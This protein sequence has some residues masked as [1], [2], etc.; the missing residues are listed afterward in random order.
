LEFNMQIKSISRHQHYAHI[1]DVTVELEFKP[2]Y[3]EYMLSERRGDKIVVAYLV[4]DDHYGDIQDLMGEATG[5]LYS[6]HRLGPR[7]DS[8]KAADAIENNVDAVLLDCY[9][10]GGQSWSMY[11]TGTQCQ[12]DTARG[13]GVWVP[14]EGLLEHLVELKG[15]KRRAQAI[16]FCKQFLETY[17][18]ILG[19]EV[20]G[21]V[22][23]TFQQDASDEDMWRRVSED[24]CWGFI[25]SK[26]SMESLQSEFFAPAVESVEEGV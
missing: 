8:E 9:D 14:D 3:E 15:K 13:A 1:D 11:G 22:V 17:N 26:D 7:G 20:Y 5:R 4:Y 6:L 24:A 18:A 21:C 2:A 19:G 23:E 16:E 12:F 25:G 10:H